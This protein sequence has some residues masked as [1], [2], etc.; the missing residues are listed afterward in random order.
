MTCVFAHR[1]VLDE[2]DKIYSQLADYLQ[3]KNVIEHIQ[4][5]DIVIMLG[6]V[7]ENLNVDRNYALF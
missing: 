7:C 1:K 6:V 4:V 5:S 2:R 3:V